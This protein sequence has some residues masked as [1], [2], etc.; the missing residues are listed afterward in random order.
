[1]DAPE[2]AGDLDQLLRTLSQDAATDGV[3]LMTPLPGGMDAQVAIRS[4][5]PHKD[6]DGQHPANLGRL[7]QRAPTFV[8]ATALG[9]LRLLEHYGVP[10]RAKRAVVVGRSSVVGLPMALLLVQA[11]ATVTVCHSRTQGL[12]HTTRDAEIVCVA[13][14]RAG[15]IGPEHVRPGVVVVDF[16]TNPT[17]EGTI[18]GDVQTREVGEIAAAITPIPGGT[19]PVTVAVL[20]EQTLKA[21]AP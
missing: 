21:A 3:L 16:G 14:G 13:A 7:V 6:V 8:P 11:D 12:A 17:S 5:D 4:L 2:S 1:V 9:G 15:L 18:V 19:G 20:G 10:L